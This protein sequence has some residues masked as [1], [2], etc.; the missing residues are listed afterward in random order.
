MRETL[1]SYSWLN[2]P[3]ECNNLFDL[4]LEDVW[5]NINTKTS[6]VKRKKFEQF[7]KM[8]LQNMFNDKH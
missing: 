8:S 3:N 1:S 6:L 7:K 5:L 2:G 4:N